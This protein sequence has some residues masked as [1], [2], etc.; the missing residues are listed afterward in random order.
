MPAIRPAAAAL[1]AAALLAAAL[2]ARADLVRLHDGKTIEG[3]VSRSGGKVTVKG[4][5]GKSA[6][7]AESEVL[8]AEA[9]EC[10]WDAAARMAKEIPADASDALFVE[11]HLQIARYVKERRQ[12]SPECAE[13]ESREY[14]LVLKKAADNDEAHAGLGHVKWGPWWFRSDKDRDAKKKNAPASEMEPLGYVKMKKTG[15]WELKEDADAIEAGKTKYRGKWVTEDEKKAAQGYVKDEKG[16]WILATDLKE[17][18]RAAEIEKDLKEKP[19]A[20]QTSRHFRLISWLNAAETAELKALAEQTYQKHRELLGWPMPKEE[21]GEDDLFPERIEVFLLADAKRKVKWVEAYGKGLGWS[22]EVYNTRVEIGSGGWY[23]VTPPYLLDGGDPGE[24]NRERDKEQDFLRAKSRVTS[25]VARIILHRVFSNHPAW[26]GEA[27]G[28]L[29]EIRMNETADCCFS[30]PSK[31]REETA[32]KQG[33]KAK[34]FDF[35]KLQIAN[36]LD[37]TLLQLFSLELNK[38]DWADIVKC[39]SF[40]EFLNAGYRTEF[41]ALLRCPLADVEEVTPAQYQA[42]IDAKSNKDPASAPIDGSK[43]KEA[44]KAPDHP[45]KIRGPQAEQV[46]EGSDLERAIH[47]AVAEQWIA[48]AIKKDVATLEKEWKEWV[49][50]KK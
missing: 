14:E 47:A 13:L 10:T 4:F 3:K 34:Y 43:P 19:V 35:M 25:M 16:N 23:S 36:H 18:E 12:Y 6:T 49:L 26:F 32:N 11:K 9:G 42:A 22:D 30:A 8:F 46:T 24:K 7:Y 41:L 15:L 48:S 27:N 21:E 45:V 31:Y 2:P 44:A 50:A 17:R 37:R 29:G 28:F 1:A 40:L 39:W 20:V 38:L 5:K 33:S